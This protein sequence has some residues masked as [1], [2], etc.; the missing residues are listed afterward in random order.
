[1][2][3]KSATKHDVASRA[4]AGV[5]SQGPVAFAGDTGDMIR[6]M[7]AGT[8]ARAIPAVAA[9]LGVSQ[10]R[11]FELLRLPKSTVKGRISKNE[12]LSA[13][14]QDRVYRAERV[15]NRAISVLEDAAAA[16]TWLNR[17]NRALGGEVP[18]AMLDTEVGYE[19]V[20]DT[21]GRIEFGVIS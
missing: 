20:L 10:E 2:V 14:E 21:L 6:Q 7:R 1:M 3:F 13:T 12:L 9:N 4:S 18:L 17:E 11:L 16:R 8:P 19:L 15:L 5:A